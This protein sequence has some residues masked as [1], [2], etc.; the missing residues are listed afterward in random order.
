MTLTR[1]LARVRVPV[2]FAVAAAAF[3]L[4]APTRASL[5]AGCALATVGEALR[6]WAAGHLEKSREVTSSGPYR[7]TRHPLYLGSTLLGAGFAVAAWH[8]VV[9]GLV[10][11]YLGLT[12]TAA[13]RAEEAHLREKFGGA[14]DAYAQRRVA[15]VARRFS[16]A[17]ALHNRE[18]HTLA[19]VV[20]AIV[21]L[22]AKLWVR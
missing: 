5:V 7:Y 1:R 8:P 19:G 22:A 9:A 20:V 6:I 18:H 15:P 11:G 12:L 17:R 13:M 16:A 3:W 4:A 10:V 2:G 21:L 14:Y